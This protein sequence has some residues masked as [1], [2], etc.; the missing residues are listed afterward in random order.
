MRGETGSCGGA[1][2]RS[3]N[4]GRAD[5]KLEWAENEQWQ[6]RRMAFFFFFL[7][8]MISF[9]FFISLISNLSL[10]YVMNL[11]FELSIHISNPSMRR[12][13]LSI[14]FHLYDIFFLLYSHGFVFNLEVK[15]P[16]SIGMLLMTHLFY[17]PQMH[18]QV[19]LSMMQ[20]LLWCLWLFTPF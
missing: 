15:F 1:R 9:L 14:Y 5:G 11:I 12:I 13:Y 16:G 19:K 7:P 18:N 3:G 10:N 8:F 4:L 20:D 6:P 17:Y 2:Q